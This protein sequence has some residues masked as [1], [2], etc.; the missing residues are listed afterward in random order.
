[1][2]NL[3]VMAAFLLFGAASP[4]RAKIQVNIDVE[5]SDDKIKKS[6]QEGMKARINSTERYSLTDSAMATDLF[7]EVDCLVLENE[8]GYKSGIVCAS[9]VTY[10]PYKGSPVSIGVEKA[11][12]L[13]VSNLTDHSFLIEKLMNRF[14][15]ATTDSELAGRKSFLRSAIQLL[16]DERPNE[17]KLPK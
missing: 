12:H 2:R 13:I 9:E 4:V 15:N 10:Y 1:M 14:I 7:M 16:C 5:V 6:L 8:D 17:C 3:L 11:A